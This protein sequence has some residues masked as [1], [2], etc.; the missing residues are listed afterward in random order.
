M[1]RMIIS[2]SWFRVDQAVHIALSDAALSEAALG[3]GGLP[4]FIGRITELSATRVRLRTDRPLS[5]GSAARLS[6]KGTQIA[7]EV[8][9]CIASGDDFLIEFDL[10]AFAQKR[11]AALTA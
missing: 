2:N 7:A 4:A 3:E 6:W 11:I 10:R 9:K 5:H 8:R 1:N